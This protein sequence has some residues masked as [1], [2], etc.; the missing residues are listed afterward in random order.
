MPYVRLMYLKVQQSKTVL[1]LDV[2]GSS[3]DRVQ[4]EEE[5]DRSWIGNIK[6]VSFNWRRKLPSEAALCREGESSKA[7]ERQQRN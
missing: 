5:L 1:P 6:E 2:K 3:T 7:G 4:P